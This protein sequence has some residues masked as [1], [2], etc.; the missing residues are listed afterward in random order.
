MSITEVW[1]APRWRE[2]A[3][4]LAGGGGRVLFRGLLRTA[5]T[6]VAAWAVVSLTCSAAGAD[7]GGSERLLAKYPALKAQLEKNQF[8]AP[9]YIDSKEGERSVQVDMYGIFP[10][11]FAAIKDALRYPPNW[12][13]I[14]SLHINIKACTTSK[15]G[16]QWY[17]TLYNGRKYYQTPSAAYPLKLKFTLQS[18]TPNY[19]EVNMAAEQGPLHTKDHRIHLEAAPLGA[20]KTFLHFS[21]AYSYGTMARMAIKSYFNTIG[22]DK[23][24]FSAVPG[25]GGKYYLVDGVRGAIERNTVRYY[26]ALESFVD[27]LN[28][29]EGV[30]FEKRLSRW[31]DLTAKYPRQLKEMDKADYLATKRREH[32]NMLT[33]QKG[34]LSF[35]QEPVG[36][37]ILPKSDGGVSSEGVNKDAGPVPATTL[38]MR[39]LP[40]GLL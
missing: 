25:K 6:L 12:C 9:I 28:Y 11:P 13:D 30:R 17:V 32:G 15:S 35:E 34:D 31:Y 3:R 21:Y 8:G 20:D 5:A 37:A 36:A 29:P 10:H 2:V 39:L 1:P 26:L 18:D 14:T 23:V 33:L 24:G 38:T 16:D 19:L 40:V 4:V 7:P 27:T 22:R